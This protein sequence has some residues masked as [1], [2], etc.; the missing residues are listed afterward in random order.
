MIVVFDN[1]IMMKQQHGTVMES[2]NM[3]RLLDLKENKWNSSLEFILSSRIESKEEIL[4]FLKV[5]RTTTTV[6]EL[7][8]QNVI[9]C[10]ETQNLLYDVFQYN[11]SIQSI[12][13]R[14]V[15]IGDD[16]IPICIPS[17]IFTSPSSIQSLRFENCSIYKYTMNSFVTM[18][19]N[20]KC[21]LTSLYMSHVNIVCEE[22]MELLSIAISNCKSL[23]TL[24][25]EQIKTTTQTAVSGVW[26]INNLLSSIGSNNSIET[27]S[28]HHMNLDERHDI[29]SI[30]Y[31]NQSI[32]SLSFN[33]NNL[34][35]ISCSILFGKECLGSNHSTLKSISL[36]YNP[37]GNDGVN[38][39]IQCLNLNTSLESLFLSNCEIWYE[40]CKVIAIGL[41][42]WNAPI[43]YLNMDHNEMELCNNE[44]YQS[45]Q[46][47]TIIRTI[48][49]ILPG[50]KSKYRNTK[51]LQKDEQ[52][53]SSSLSD[54]CWNNVDLYLRYNNANR[55]ELKN[56]IHMSQSECILSYFL[57]RPCI[58]SDPEILYFFIKE[59]IHSL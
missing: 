28:L 12:T 19:T 47:N 51:L 44:L 55:N 10:M 59:L 58:Q 32:T 41:G 34:N 39:I 11:T 21:C 18:T 16:Y 26:M 45:L 57:S 3:K 5:L 30:L 50:S 24:H 23:Q 31:N 43:T 4:S 53:S 15:V 35:S 27:V 40:G 13:I 1:G 7:V 46:H 42:T 38:Y 36:S 54:D 20:D 17:T 33:H 37:I 8:I 52:Q 22:G 9:L 25:L 14:K 6:H 2:Y 29:G 49:S 56:V 48:L